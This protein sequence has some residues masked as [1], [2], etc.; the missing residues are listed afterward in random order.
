MEILRLKD[1]LANKVLMRGVVDEIRL[2]SIF[3]YP[4]DTVYGIGCNAE[5]TDS[6]NTVR[7]IKHTDHPFSV[8][9]PSKNWVNKKLK[10]IHTEYLQRLPG[11][12]TLIFKKKREDYL[13]P[14]SQSDS[15]GVRI[16]KHSFSD[17]I[18]RA[19]VPFVTTSANISGQ[20]AISSPKKIPE[21]IL[22]QIDFVLD[23][24]VISGKPSTVIDLTAD[25]PKVIRK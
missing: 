11:P 18:N 22:Q 21:K 7:E 15:L 9:V 17:I 25:E 24:G 10:V 4:T 16:P 12:Y 19:G 8:I 3:I 5:E 13:S 23:A 2:G 20:P 6:V 14:V 1:I